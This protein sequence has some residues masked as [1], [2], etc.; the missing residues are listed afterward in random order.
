MNRRERRRREDKR[1]LAVGAVLAVT[2][3]V[4][5]MDALADECTDYRVPR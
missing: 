3:L 4:A 5:A 2:M 1:W